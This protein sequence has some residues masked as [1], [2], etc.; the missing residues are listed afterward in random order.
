[1]GK[2]ELYYYFFNLKTDSAD[3]YISLSSCSYTDLSKISYLGSRV[4]SVF[5]Y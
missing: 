2:V 1:M 4:F 5:V 3:H